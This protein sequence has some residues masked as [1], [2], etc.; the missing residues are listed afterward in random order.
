MWRSPAWVYTSLLSNT[1]V[2]LLIRPARRRADEDRRPSSDAAAFICCQRLS[3]Q[4][5]IRRVRKVLAEVER[6]DCKLHLIC[7]S[8]VDVHADGASPPGSVAL[9]DL[10]GNTVGVLVRASG[11]A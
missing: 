1:N 6:K 5:K 8:E 9:S 11:A 2:W 3:C 7:V 10:K 4:R